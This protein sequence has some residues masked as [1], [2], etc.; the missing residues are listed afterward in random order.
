[1]DTV[2]ASECKARCLALMDQVAGSGR[3]LLITKNGRPV[4]ELWPHRAP[5]VASPIGLHKGKIE[6]TGDIIASVPMD[7]DVLK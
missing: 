4:A 7:W 6:I 1:M 3:P 5:R 2:Q